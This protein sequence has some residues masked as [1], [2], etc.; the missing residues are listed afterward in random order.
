MLPVFVGAIRSWLRDD[1]VKNCVVSAA[2]RLIHVREGPEQIDQVEEVKS[3]IDKMWMLVELA[4]AS[5]GR[6]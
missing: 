5:P 4:I 1:P 3:M 2:E 6:V